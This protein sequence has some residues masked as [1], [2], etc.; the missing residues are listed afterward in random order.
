MANGGEER[1]VRN[2]SP[3]DIDDLSAEGK[4]IAARRDWVLFQPPIISVLSFCCTFIYLLFDVRC[5]GRFD[6]STHVLR[7]LCPEY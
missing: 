6:Y 7:R 5:H 1:N 2:V 3:S 4:A